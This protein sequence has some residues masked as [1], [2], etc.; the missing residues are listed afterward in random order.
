VRGATLWVVDPEVRWAIRPT[1]AA[2]APFLVSMLV[3]AANW[4]PDRPRRSVEETLADRQ[5]A[6]YLDGWPRADDFGVIAIDELAAAIGACWARCLPTDDP[7]Y[8][9]VASDVPEIGVAVIAQSRRRG[10]GRTL[11]RRVAEEGRR[12]GVQRLSLSVERTNPASHLYRS[13][14]WRT[15]STAAGSDTMV[16]DLNKPNPSVAG[17]EDMKHLAGS[18]EA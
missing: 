8:G 15:V 4:S 17:V 16:L 3:E 1:E 13:E 11:L 6:H 18:H 5:V 9:Y 14:G 10:V 7:G 12:T 2:D